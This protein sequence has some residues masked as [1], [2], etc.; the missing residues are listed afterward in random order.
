MRTFWDK[1]PV[2]Q[3]GLNYKRGEDIE[4]EKKVVEEPVKLPN[5]FSWKVCSVKRLIHS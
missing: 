5:G 3:E 1:Q 2:P 4:K